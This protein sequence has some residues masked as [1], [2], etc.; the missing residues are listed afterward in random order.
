MTYKAAGYMVV[1]TVCVAPGRPAGLGVWALGVGL[2][3][4]RAVRNPNL[5]V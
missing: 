1:L 4:F 5:I 3:V 2:L